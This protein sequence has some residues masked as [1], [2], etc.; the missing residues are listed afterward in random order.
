MSTVA[1]AILDVIGARL[2][3]VALGDP[4]ITS[5]TFTVYLRAGGGWPRGVTMRLETQDEMQGPQNGG[6]PAW[7]A[8]GPVGRRA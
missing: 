6:E 2:R 3:S 1:A 8:C 4:A 5:V 7:D